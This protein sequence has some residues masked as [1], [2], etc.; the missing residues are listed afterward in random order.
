[1]SVAVSPT[2]PTSR[3]RSP[4]AG[5]EPESRTPAGPGRQRR[6]GG[7][8]GPKRPR[9]QFTLLGLIV[10]MLA[11]SMIGAILFYFVR[12]LQT[13]EQSLKL[14][15]MVAVLAGPLLLTILASLLV[16]LAQRIGRN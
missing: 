15:G 7:Q 2:P 1:M 16:A 4:S 3:D 10:L 5:A 13:G 12:G 6:P 8:G 11:A 14:V 9:L